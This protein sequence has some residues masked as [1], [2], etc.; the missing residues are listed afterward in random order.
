M[1]TSAAI[2][3]PNGYLTKNEIA[4]RLRCTPRNIENWMRRGLPHIPFGTRKTLFKPAAVDEFMAG[5][6]GTAKPIPA[7]KPKSKSSSKRK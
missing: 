7:I 2:I 6:P 4:A 1:A 5:L 3:E